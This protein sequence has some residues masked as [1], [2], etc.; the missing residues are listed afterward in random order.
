MNKRQRFIPFWAEFHALREALGKRMR[1]LFHVRKREKVLGRRRFGRGWCGEFR[2]S[3]VHLGLRSVI[4]E[5]DG[6]E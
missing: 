4:S 3:L 2:E 1:V 6:Y 5:V